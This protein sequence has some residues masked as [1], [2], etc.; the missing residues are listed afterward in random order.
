MELRH[1]DKSE[2]AIQRSMT[3]CSR[4]RGEQTNK[5]LGMNLVR[6]EEQKVDSCGWRGVNMGVGGKR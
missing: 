6:L 4:K 2:A 5:Y 3:G 1:N